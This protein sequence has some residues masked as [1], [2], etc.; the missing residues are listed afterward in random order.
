MNTFI[1]H[2]NHPGRANVLA[3]LIAFLGKLPIAKSWQIEVKAYSKSRSNQQNRYLNGCAYAVI[4]EAL[5][6]DRDDISEYLCGVYFG[7]RRRDLPGGRHEQ[8]PIRTTT[9]DEAGKRAVLSTKD[10]ADYVE[11]VQRFAAEHGIYVPDPE[12]DCGGAA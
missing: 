11:F 8:V 9:T 12:P 4:G 2:A 1:L 6:Y 7:W 3:N 5:G 10:F